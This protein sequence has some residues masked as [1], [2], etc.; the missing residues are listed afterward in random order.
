[1]QQTGLKALAVPHGKMTYSSHEKTQFPVP[2]RVANRPTDLA[3][4]TLPHTHTHT[5]THTCMQSF[6]LVRW[7]RATPHAPR[8]TFSSFHQPSLFSIVASSSTP[9]SSLPRMPA[10]IPQMFHHWG[11]TCSTVSTPNTNLEDR[12]FNF[13]RWLVI[14][15]NSNNCKIKLIIWCVFMVL[16]Y[17]FSQNG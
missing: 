8:R 16:L 3:H 11:V 6:R 15:T 7:L 10:V 9:P 14:K 1:M 12:V 17:K 5:H 2:L 13:C 4:Q